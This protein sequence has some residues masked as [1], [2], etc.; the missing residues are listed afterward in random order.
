M[1]RMITSKQAKG[2]EKLNENIVINEDGTQVEIG[3]NVAIDSDVEVGGNIVVDSIEQ[4]GYMGDSDVPYAGHLDFASQ[5]PPITADTTVATN[6]TSLVVTVG[7]PQE[8]PT[9]I[10]FLIKNGVVVN[11]GTLY[12]YIGDNAYYINDVS[13]GEF[14]IV[15]D[16]VINEDTES[17]WSN[18]QYS[19]QFKPFFTEEQYE[20]L[21]ALIENA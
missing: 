15:G 2:L 14:D 7:T 3:G 5:M 1:R 10:P 6:V 18:L 20:A 21:L 8:C 13:G 11:G 19:K 9:D 16:L 4:L 17:H 12:W